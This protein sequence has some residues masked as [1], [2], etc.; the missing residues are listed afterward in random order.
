MPSRIMV[1]KIGY[2][3]A[4]RSAMVH[5][6]HTGVAYEGLPDLHSLTSLEG[7]VPSGSSSSNSTQS[8]EAFTDD[9]ATRPGNDTSGSSSSGSPSRAS[10]L[11]Q[12][13]SPERF[14]TS[15]QLE[16]HV[17]P[18]S[19]ADASAC[20]RWNAFGDAYEDLAAAVVAGRQPCSQ[21]SFYCILYTTSS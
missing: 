20:V 2:R 21:V 16:S 14:H 15:P 12:Q 7:S 6:T 5:L 17:P 1:A 13:Q 9:R 11:Q 19:A 8:S 4:H 10:S 3:N 18:W